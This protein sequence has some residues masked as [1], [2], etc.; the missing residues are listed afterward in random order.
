MFRILKKTVQTGL[1]T[2]AYPET[3]ATMPENFRGA[4]RFDFAHW[5]DAR[6]AAESCPTEAISIRDSRNAGE[7]AREV[8]VDYGLCIHCGQ[9]AEADSSGAVRITRE[10]TLAARERGDLVITAE[11]AL[12]ADGTQGEVRSLRQNC[13]PAV[14]V[15]ARIE[16]QIQRRIHDVLGGSLAI[17]EVDAGSCNGC[18]VEISALNSPVYDL[19]RLGI[20]FVASPRHADM[21]LVTGPV[22]RNMEFAL[23][24]AYHAT[25]D[26][27]VVV[28]VGACGISGGIFGRNYATIGGVDQAVPVDV[29]IPGCP[30]R[31]HALLYGILLAVGRMEWKGLP[32]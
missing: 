9:C 12:N 2:I 18:E 27:K 20:H 1:V 15:Q 25:P 17:R 11:Y 30:P 4:P 22:T 14:Q 24:K 13:P 26:P 10:F 8:T 23:R 31:P 3:P 32:Q 6:P 5:R 29:F 21:L 28:A 19:E 16:E 7:A